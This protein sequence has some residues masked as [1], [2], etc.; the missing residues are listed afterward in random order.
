[1]AVVRTGPTTAYVAESRR[2]KQLDATACSS[3][4]LIYKIGPAAFTGNGPVRVMD[5]TPGVPPP[6]GCLPL[7][8]EAYRPGQSFTDPA[9]G[10]RIDV[11]STASG[12]DTIRI[13]RT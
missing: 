13:S 10:V 6:S 7:D 4:V 12:S 2:T 5:S 9:S 3:G 1:L 8:D 11:L